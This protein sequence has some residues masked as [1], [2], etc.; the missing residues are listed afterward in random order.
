M[1]S[2]LHTAAFTQFASQVFGFPGNSDPETLLRVF[3]KNSNPVITAV[4]FLLIRRQNNK[5]KALLARLATLLSALDTTKLVHF[6]KTAAAQI[7]TSLPLA[8]LDF[9]MLLFQPYLLHN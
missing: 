7:N 5:L 9:A 6:W 3:N 8:F 4:G 2:H 1:R